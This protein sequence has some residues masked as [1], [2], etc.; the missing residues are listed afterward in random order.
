MPD[1]FEDQDWVRTGV[2]AAI[3]RSLDGA[4]PHALQAVADLLIKL[5]PQRT[6]LEYKGLLSKK[7]FRATVTLGEDALSLELDAM[8]GLIAS[9]VHISRGIAL[10]RELWPLEQWVAELVEALEAKAAAD[11]SARRALEAW[12]GR[13]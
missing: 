8:G 11:E 5:L 13:D 7:L 1:S 6:K 4:G 2:A 9:C 3:V 10:K 12:L